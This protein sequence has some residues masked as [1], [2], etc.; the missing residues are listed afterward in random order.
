MHCAQE[1]VTSLAC[2]ICETFKRNRIRDICVTGFQKGRERSDPQYHKGMK[3]GIFT[4][5]ARF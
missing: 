3:K 5:R 2:N 1:P 4:I